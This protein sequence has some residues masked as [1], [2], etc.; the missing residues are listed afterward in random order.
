MAT[1]IGSSDSAKLF[2]NRLNSHFKEIKLANFNEFLTFSKNPSEY[3]KKI[4]DSLKSK[5]I[6]ISKNRPG[7]KAQIKAQKWALGQ[8]K[9][10]LGKKY[11][12][13]KKVYGNL[14]DKI[15]EEI[16]DLQQE[17]DRLEK[18]LSS[19]FASLEVDKNELPILAERRREA[20]TNIINDIKIFSKLKKNDEFK[21][22]LKG[23]YGEIK[24]IEYISD[25]YKNCENYYLINGY[26]INVIAKAINVDD[27]TLVENKIDHILI[28]HKGIF[29]LETKSW[30]EIPKGGPDK[31]KN[32]FKKIIAVFKNRFEGQF[33]LSNFE[34]VLVTTEKRI[35]ISENFGFKSL[36]LD[37]LKEYIFNKPDLYSQ[38]E[39]T[40]IVNEL[41]PNRIVKMNVIRPQK[42]IR[43][44]NFIEKVINS[45]LKGLRED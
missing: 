35:V 2:L 5:M 12:T 10:K 13:V 8:T 45:F 30:K 27:H 33:F 43:P 21:M 9:Y 19:L 14:R 36:G 42:T 40:L 3:L 39:I 38:S 23:A 44:T 22:I 28:C 7:I 26:D 29:I 15:N 25:C 34:P 41:L 11:V 24:V 32:Q 6:E 18:S 31:I 17:K 1:I 16:D 37:E 4:D 20:R